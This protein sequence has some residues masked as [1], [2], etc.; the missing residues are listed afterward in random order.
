ME[1]FGTLCDS[2]KREMHE[3]FSDVKARLDRMEARQDRQGGLLQGGGRAMARV[4]DGTRRRPVAE[5]G[6]RLAA[7]EERV[8]KLEN[9][10]AR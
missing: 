4:I 6:R 1:F 10:G 3:E 5:R 2:L 9:G 8:R 7:L